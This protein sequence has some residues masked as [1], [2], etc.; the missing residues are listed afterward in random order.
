[1]NLLC[2]IEAPVQS[3]C[4]RPMPASHQLQH[5]SKF[6]CPCGSRVDPTYS[7]RVESK[8]GMGNA[9]KLD[10]TPTNHHF[11]GCW[12]RRSLSPTAR[13]GTGRWCGSRDPWIEHRLADHSTNLAR[14]R[15]NTTLVSQQFSSEPTSSA[16]NPRP[17]RA[18]GSVRKRQPR[19]G[20]PNHL[21]CFGQIAAEVEMKKL[22]RALTCGPSKWAP[23]ATGITSPNHGS[24]SN[25]G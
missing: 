6:F 1:M 10:D 3:E 23:T 19:L 25:H 16:V 9:Y 8:W 22:R 13:G 14:H 5:V 4:C 20:S 11:G 17:L 2:K 7:L 18:G 15:Q 12:L 21:L 24:A